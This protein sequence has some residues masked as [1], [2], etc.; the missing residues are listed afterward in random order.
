MKGRIAL[1]L[2]AALLC[3]LEPVHAVLHQN[4]PWLPEPPPSNCPGSI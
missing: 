3:Q 2:T 1:L 4:L